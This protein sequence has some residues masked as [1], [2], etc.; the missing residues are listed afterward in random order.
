MAGE[1]AC[2]RCGERNLWQLDSLP[3]RGGGAP[4][5]LSPTLKMRARE[6]SLA[7]FGNSVRE[8]TDTVGNGR[9]ALLICTSCG[10]TRWYARDVKPDPEL[11]E[12]NHRCADCD[13]HRFWR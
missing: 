8:K 2:P 5:P 4:A 6:R 3:D 1:K 10:H 13:G 12:I 7:T 9:F 11:T